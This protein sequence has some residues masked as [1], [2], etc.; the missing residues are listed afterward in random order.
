M[1]LVAADE[2]AANMAEPPDQPALEYDLVHTVGP[3]ES[4]SRSFTAGQLEPLAALVSAG[5]IVPG[6]PSV[7][8]RERIRSGDAIDLRDVVTHAL[9]LI[10]R[11]H[12]VGVMPKIP[13]H[14]SYNPSRPSAGGFVS[15]EGVPVS[16][17]VGC[18]AMIPL[19][20]RHCCPAPRRSHPTI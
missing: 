16:I 8:E 2:V 4:A 9:A 10:D 18:C 3:M 7:I 14:N 12:I 17:D 5:F 15:E 11:I 1:A 20:R 13:V 6:P 19:R